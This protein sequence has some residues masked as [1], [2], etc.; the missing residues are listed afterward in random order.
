MHDLEV[1]VICHEANRAYCAQIGDDSQVP[2]NDAPQWQQDSAILGVR[3]VRA[4]PNAGDAAQHEN[5]MKQKLD[6]GWTYGP[7]KDPA[8]KEH[9]C[10]VPFHELPREQQLKD[11]LFRAVVLALS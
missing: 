5:W 11:R 2:W 7:I 6:E 8:K 10:L 9:H 3:F 1:A 4:N